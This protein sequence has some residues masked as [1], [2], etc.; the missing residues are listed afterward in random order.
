MLFYGFRLSGNSSGLKGILNAK[1]ESAKVYI[2]PQEPLGGSNGSY[3][4][5]YVYIVNVVELIILE[6]HTVTSTVHDDTAHDANQHTMQLVIYFPWSSEYL[7]RR[8]FG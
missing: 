8:S 7:L 5:K 1:Q 2:Y 4:C 3:G 6:N